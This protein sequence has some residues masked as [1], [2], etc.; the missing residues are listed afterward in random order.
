MEG[1]HDYHKTSIDIIVS[2]ENITN[3]DY[4]VPP[5]LQKQIFSCVQMQKTQPASYIAILTLTHV[6]CLFYSKLNNLHN[7]YY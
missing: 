3:A 6:L 2:Q 7:Y 1:V 5:K 4:T